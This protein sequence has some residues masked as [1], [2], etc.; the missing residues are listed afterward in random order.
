MRGE[1]SLS[2]RKHPG[3]AGGRLR[4]WLVRWLGVGKAQRLKAE[5]RAEALVTAYR[6]KL[7]AELHNLK[8]MDVVKPF[9]PS[10]GLRASWAQDRL[11]SEQ[12]WEISGQ[13][14]LLRA[15]RRMVRLPPPDLAG[16]LCCCGY[17]QKGLE[18][19]WRGEDR[20]EPARLLVGGDGAV[21]GR[22]VRGCYAPPGGYPGPG[23]RYLL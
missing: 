14:D 22:G 8:I 19:G 2:S 15:G 16:V 5:T 17:Q 18:E 3:H 7:L 1:I 6:H 13:H 21:P 20:G 4:G 9:D 23:R 12:G 10:T 11:R